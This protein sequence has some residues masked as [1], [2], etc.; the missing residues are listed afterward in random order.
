LFQSLVQ[1]LCVAAEKV[2]KKEQKKKTQEVPAA[3]KKS[4]Y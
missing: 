3:Q 4:C 2:G 1:G